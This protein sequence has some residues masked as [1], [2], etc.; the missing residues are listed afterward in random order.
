MTAHILHDDNMTETRNQVQRLESRSKPELK[1]L[2]ASELGE[3]FDGEITNSLRNDFM[4]ACYERI[5]PTER[6]LDRAR[7]HENYSDSWGTKKTLATALRMLLTE[8]VGRREHESIT[9]VSKLVLAELIVAVKLTDAGSSESGSS[10]R[11]PSSG[12]TSSTVTGE[13]PPVRQPPRESPFDDVLPLEPSI[14]KR[15]VSEWG[16]AQQ[17]KSNG[18]YAVY[19][20]DC[21]PPIGAGESSQL[22]SLRRHAHS[23][24]AERQPLN[25]IDEAACAANNNER[26]YYVG[27]TANLPKRITQHLGGAAAGGGDFTNLFK[28]N[29]LVEVNWYETR[30]TAENHE[31]LRASELTKTGKSYG[32]YE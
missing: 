6:P 7:T 13:S 19:V 12:S 2:L 29:A 15:D 30:A 21:T 3:T 27:C 23:K 28:P 5:N 16:S 11:P 14:Q 20:L 17:N 32:Y 25:K 9:S 4:R 26:V 24:N 10:N 22:K 18:A 1:Q 31:A 8:R